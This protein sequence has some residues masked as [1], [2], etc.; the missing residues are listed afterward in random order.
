MLKQ[1]YSGE[2]DER[3]VTGEKIRKN[4]EKKKIP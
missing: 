3:K 2:S 1:K 4:L